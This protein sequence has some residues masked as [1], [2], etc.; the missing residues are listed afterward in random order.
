[1]QIQNTTQPTFGKLYMPKYKT[2]VKK[3]GKE[4][5]TTLEAQ[6][7][8]AEE[9]AA[10]YDVYVTDARKDPESRLYATLEILP[11]R[12]KE[13]SRRKTRFSW[14]SGTSDEN[15][16]KIIKRC[17][18]HSETMLIEDTLIENNLA[19]RNETK[20]FPRN[21]YGQVL[22]LLREYKLATDTNNKQAQKQILEKLDLINITLGKYGIAKESYEKYIVPTVNI[23]E[24]KITEN[25]I[26]LKT[27]MDALQNIGMDMTVYKK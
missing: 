14:G 6:R 8:A 17:I 24:E 11:L 3:Y 22:A 16:A 19:T 5:A 15:L 25:N 26:P 1:M 21:Y 2:L 9:A 10:K 18:K 27:I 7:P 23:I 20:S 13:N 12:N 4:I